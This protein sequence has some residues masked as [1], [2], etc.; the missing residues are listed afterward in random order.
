MRFVALKKERVFFY[1]R[2]RN[3]RTVFRMVLEGGKRKGKKK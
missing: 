2:E 1:S 3:Q